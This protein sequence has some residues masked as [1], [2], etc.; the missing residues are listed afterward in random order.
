L[1]RGDRRGFGGW[2]G[3]RQGDSGDLWH[4]TLIDPGLFRMLGKLPKGHRVLDLGCGNGYL[5][6]RLARAGA[7]V[8]GIDRS[9]ELLAQ[10]RRSERAEPLGITYLRSD[11]EHLDRL[12]D[13]SFDLAF[14]NMALM[15]IKNAGGAIR[16][17]GRVVRPGGR[18]VFSISHPCFDV[19]TRSTWIEEITAGR[20]GSKVFRKVTGYREIHSDR[21]DW[22]LERGGTATTVGYHRPLEWYAR[23]LRAAGFLLVDLHEPSP[24][25]GFVSRRIQKA[26]IEEIPMHLVVEALRRDGPAR[27][28]RAGGVPAA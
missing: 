2:Y 14:S 20:R 1:V 18:F 28:R 22:A 13:A 24:Q 21:Y 12:K 9:A 27:P 23:V 17:V 11:A 4:R 3:D 7:A 25:A 15:D 26:W 10:A 5:A 19:D 16:E 6:R 8:V